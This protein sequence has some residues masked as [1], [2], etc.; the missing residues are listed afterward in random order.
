MIALV[1]LLPAVFLKREHK[2]ATPVP[3]PAQPRQ[4]ASE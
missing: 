4:A 3:V 1:G 2:P